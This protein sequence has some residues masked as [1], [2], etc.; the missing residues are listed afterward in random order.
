MFKVKPNVDAMDQQLGGQQEGDGLHSASGR[1][2]NSPLQQYLQYDP[3]ATLILRL[4]A[5]YRGWI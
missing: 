3:E 4:F 2:K 5:K 1:Q